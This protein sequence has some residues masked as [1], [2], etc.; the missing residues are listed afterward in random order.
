MRRDGVLVRIKPE[1][2]EEVLP[3]E[4]AAPMTEAEVEAPIIIPF[5]LLILHRYGVPVA[6]ASA[7]GPASCSSTQST[8][9]ARASALRTLANMARWRFRPHQGKPAE[10]VA[11]GKDWRFLDELKRELKA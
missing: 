3:V 4:P 8:Q 9:K 1:G 7:P 10:I 5:E 2:T 11:D 6:S